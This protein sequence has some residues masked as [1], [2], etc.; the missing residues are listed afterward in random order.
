MN[1]TSIFFFICQQQNTC[2]RYCTSFCTISTTSLAGG[3][4]CGYKPLFP[5]C[6]Y[7]GSESSPSALRSPAG[8]KEPFLFA[9]LY[10]LTRKRVNILFQ[11]HFVILIS[12][13]FLLHNSLSMCPTSTRI[14]WYITLLLFFG[15]NAIWYL[16]SDLVCAKL[17][18]SILDTSFVLVRLANLHLL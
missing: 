14:C 1:Y 10:R 8:S 15:A 11:C 16:H 7:R 12:I 13:P 5:A 6:I 9:L 4:L 2:G 3:L 17:F 18:L